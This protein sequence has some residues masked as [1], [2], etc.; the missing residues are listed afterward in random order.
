MSSKMPKNYFR[1]FRDFPSP[2]QLQKQLL[3]L[4]K[5]LKTN[6]RQFRDLFLLINSETGFV[7][8]KVPKT[9]FGHFRH[10]PSQLLKQ[11][12]CLLKSLKTNFRHFREILCPHQTVETSFI[13]S[14]IPKN[15]LKSFQAPSFSS[16]VEITC[17]SSK[18]PKN[19]F[20]SFQGPF[21]S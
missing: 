11:L 1:H 7:C 6:F 9:S 19:K 5:S 13:C 2:Y 4:L 17:T 21:F 10:S 3:C 12:V 20:C 16:T 14:K 18:I 15:K 8:S